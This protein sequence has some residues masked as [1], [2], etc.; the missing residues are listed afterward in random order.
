MPVISSFYNSWSGYNDELVWGA[1]WLSRATT[2]T[3]SASYLAKAQSY[4]A[5]LNREGQ[6]AFPVYKWTY[7]W[8]DKAVASE[9]LLAKLTGEPST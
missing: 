6:S 5:N 3:E 9:I 7:D 1:I 8:D 4:Y 2:G